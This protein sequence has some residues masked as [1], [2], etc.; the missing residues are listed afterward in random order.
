MIDINK[1]YVNIKLEIILIWLE[2]LGR[3]EFLSIH[4][5]NII[6]AISEFLLEEEFKW[7]K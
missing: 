1:V 4:D 3:K 6:S 2:R 5:K 7:R